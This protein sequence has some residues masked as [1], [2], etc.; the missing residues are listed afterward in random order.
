MSSERGENE[1]R[2]HRNVGYHV[3]RVKTLALKGTKTK[4][5]STTKKQ[6]SCRCDLHP[7]SHE[8]Q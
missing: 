1:M 2:D 3:G 8:H 6:S 7:P 4:S 5:S